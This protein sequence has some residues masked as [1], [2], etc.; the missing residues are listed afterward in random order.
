M[1]IVPVGPGEYIDTDTGEY[2]DR[3]GNPLSRYAPPRFPPGSG[4][5]NDA[6]G[7]RRHADGSLVDPN[8]EPRLG[9]PRPGQSAR[10]YFNNPDFNPGVRYNPNSPSD[11]VWTDG[12]AVNPDGS[13]YNGPGRRAGE[14]FRDGWLV[15]SSSSGTPRDIYVDVDG[16]VTGRRGTSYYYDAQGDPHILVTGSSSS[17]N[18]GSSGGGSFPSPAHTSN[19]ESRSGGFNNTSVSTNI[20]DITP[21]AAAAQLALAAQPRTSISD[22]GPVSAALQREQMAQEAARYNAQIREDR[23]SNIVKNLSHPNDM[24]EREYSIRALQAPAGTPYNLGNLDNAGLP[25]IGNG[26]PISTLA[27]TQASDAPPGNPPPGYQWA[28]RD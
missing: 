27:N 4:D 14:N 21:A 1:A 19:S 24:V 7:R 23:I 26:P 10:D 16:R 5:Y 15:T 8:E 22:I 13:P 18:S 28:W 20:T 17:G 12:Q 2:V 9:T 6:E 25:N 11:W 3:D